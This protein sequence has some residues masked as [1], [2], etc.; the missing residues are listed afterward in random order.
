M[1]LLTIVQDAIAEVSGARAPSYVVG[2]Q[3]PNVAKALGM[4][5]R[6]GR[7]IQRSFKW[8][9]LKTTYT[10][11]TV[12]GQAAYPLP[13]TWQ[14]MSNTSQWD[15]TSHWPLNGPA[16]DAFWQVLKSGIIVAGMRFWFRIE[17]DNFVIAPVPTVEHVI[18]YDWF[19]DTWVSTAAG[20]P[21]QSMTADT[22]YPAFLPRARAEDLMTLGLIYTL[23]QNVGLPY[24]E[25]K[26]NYLQALDAEQFDCR[27]QPVIDVTGTPRYVTGR[28]NLPEINFG[29]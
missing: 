1:T 21:A 2:N 19:E 22:D 5:N 18:A 16:T 13:T 10:F 9:M 7:D 29:V 25:A 26:A 15:R 20:V 24:G 3:D 14:R 4:V 17:G 27:G 6:L 28:G 8:P 11:T 12:V 23:R